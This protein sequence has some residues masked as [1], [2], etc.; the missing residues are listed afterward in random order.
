MG[1]KKALILIL[2]TGTAD[3]RVQLGNRLGFRAGV[4]QVFF[5]LVMADRTGQCGMFGCLLQCLDLTVTHV[6]LLTAIIDRLGCRF[7]FGGRQRRDRQQGTKPDNT[8]CNCQFFVSAYR[9][10][11]S[12]RVW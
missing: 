4:G 6:T 2:V 10:L 3:R 5:G 1:G 9:I 7:G 12:S 8:C 11:L